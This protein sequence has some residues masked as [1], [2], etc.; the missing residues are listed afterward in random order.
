MRLKRTE[1]DTRNIPQRAKNV[2]NHE[3]PVAEVPPLRSG[4]E[5]KLTTN[6]IEIRGNSDSAKVPPS[7]SGKNE[8]PGSGNNTH[9]SGDNS[10]KDKQGI[11][12]RSVNSFS[13]KVPPTRSG[14]NEAP[15]A[16]TTNT[17]NRSDSNSEDNRQGSDLKA[18]NRHSAEV[19][20]SRSGKN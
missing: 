16:G 6:N 11:D 14:E 13:A 12:S 20:P 5:A 19:P 10:R 4:K 9:D 17:H 3:I 8:A 15:A 7:R 18:V 2:A 1:A